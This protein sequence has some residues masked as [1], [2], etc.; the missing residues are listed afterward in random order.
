MS[1]SQLHLGRV[2][3]AQKLRIQQSF[4]D[5]ARECLIVYQVPQVLGEC[6]VRRSRRIIFRRQCRLKVEG[7]LKRW[8]CMDAIAARI[9][10]I[11]FLI[12][13]YFFWILLKVSFLFFGGMRMDDF[14]CGGHIAS[15]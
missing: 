14:F 6:R 2:D 15:W 12:A 4:D 3:V 10:R 8:L 11:L 1:A 7:K 13:R 5:E 9:E